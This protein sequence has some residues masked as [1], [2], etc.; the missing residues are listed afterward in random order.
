[1][2]VRLFSRATHLMVIAGWLAL[3]LAAADKDAGAAKV[4]TGPSPR[5]SPEA[6]VFIDSLSVKLMSDSAAA[7]IRF[8]L[9]GTE[10]SEKS[11]PYT[12]ELKLT[13]TTLVRAR[14]FEGNKPAGPVVSQAY[15]VI[16]KDLENFTSNLPLVILNTFGREIEKANKIFGAV[17]FIDIQGGKSSLLQSANFDGHGDVHLRGNSSLRYLKRSFGLKTRDD[18]GAARS[19]SILGFPKESDWVLYA[20]YPDK[21]LIRDVLAYDLSRQM[22]HYASRTKFVEVFLNQVGGKLS[23]R[24]YMGVYVLEEK[25]KRHKDR[26]NIAKL[27]PEDNSEPSI[28]GG[29]LFKKDHWDSDED[30]TPTVEGRPNGMGGSSGSRYGYPTGPEGF[31]GDP[32]GF[33]PPVGGVRRATGSIDAPRRMPPEGSFVDRLATLLGENPAPRSPTPPAD[34]PPL[35]PNRPQGQARQFREYRDPDTGERRMVEVTRGQTPAGVGR[36]GRMLTIRSSNGRSAE[37]FR[38]TQRNEFFYVE[39]KPDEITPAQQAW[40]QNHLNE[41]EGVLYGPD[42]K[43]PAKGYAAYIDPGSFIDQHL[44]VEVTKNIDGFRFSTFFQKDR[45]G[46]IKMEPIWDWNLSFGNANG[47]QGWMAE[48]WYWPQ[49]D[50]TQYT[51]FRRLFEDPDFGQ[52]YVD[53]WA[54]LHATVFS[55]SNMLAK[56]DA[57]VADLGEARARNYERWPILGRAIWPN[58]YIGRT[59]EDEINYLKDFIRKRLAWID[60]QFIAAPSVS[61]GKPGESLTLTADAGKIYYT[62]DGSDPRA[63]G[64][65][66]S[67]KA[68]AYGSTIKIQKPGQLFARTLHQDR[69]SPPLRR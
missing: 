42:F 54:E 2:L 40:L 24:H 49:L 22:G 34:S 43:H 46:K 48:H 38:T 9:N 47:K 59:Y 21:A 18:T 68:V 16:A 28:T 60:R 63:S 57:L 66:V 19:V 55:E 58:K 8:T 6:G 39:P 25:V 12:Q 69:W 53:R 65:A 10:P 13:A 5:F 31:P 23:K 20:P 36:E 3:P 52:R 62:L 32:A 50:D 1:M 30:V 37:T 41:F 17:R 7:T 26:V 61:A 11:E 33:L 56:I 67:S 35:P 45:G 51:W 15:T 44:M 29:Y 14:V 27:T 64:G 4:P